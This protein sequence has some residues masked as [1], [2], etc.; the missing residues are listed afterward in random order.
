MDIPQNWQLNC[1]AHTL[2]SM[3]LGGPIDYFV[4]V[5]SMGELKTSL[6]I[7]QEKGLKIKIIGGGSNLL[8]ADQGFRGLVIQPA[9]R[10]IQQLE[11]EEAKKLQSYQEEMQTYAV[12]GRYRAENT[13]D[14]LKLEEQISEGKI[15]EPVLV[16][17]GAGVNWGQAVAWSLQH[18]LA[19][20]HYFARIPC[21]VG[22]AVYNNI[23]AEKRLLSDR[24][25]LVKALDPKTGEI[26]HYGTKDLEFGYDQSRFHQSCEVI[27]SAIFQLDSVSPEQNKLNQQQYLDWTKQKVAVQPSG[28][29]CGSVF[30]NFTQHVVEAKGYTAVAAGWYVDQCGLKGK[31]I[32]EMQVYPTHGNFIIN[33]GQGTQVDFIQLVKEIRETVFKRFG[34]WLEPE[35]EC[36]NEQGEV[37]I[38]PQRVS[39]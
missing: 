8:F 31:Q 13:A 35:V 2:T 15:G 4:K 30:Q 37:H 17:M 23:H 36:I 18:S 29:N 39:G 6:K 22:G 24:I 34:L 10:E 11:S 14:F 3:K 5:V 20:L 9:F 32:G 16:E 33:L 28:P 12:T 25:C 21:Q 38:W 1:E 27:I 19:G 26:K 7:A